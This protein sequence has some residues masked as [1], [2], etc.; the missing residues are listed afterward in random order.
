[1]KKKLFIIIAFFILIV[2]VTYPL[3]F[4]IT[5]CMPG[6]SSTD[7]SVASVWQ[8]W[9]IK[10]SWQNKLSLVH[11]QL[12]S[13]PFGIDMISPVYN[14]Y[15]WLFIFYALSL[16]TTP[17]LTYNLQIILNLFLSC[18]FTYLLAHLITKSRMGAFFSAICFAFCPYQFARVWQHLGLTYNQWIPLV[19]F[20]VFLL[21]KNGS[22]KTTF[23]FALSLLLLFSF[24]WTIMFLGGFALGIYLLYELIYIFKNKFYADRD[25]IREEKHYWKRIVIAGLIVFVMLLPQFMPVIK[26]RLA[27][28]P[29]SEGSAYNFHRRPFEDLFLQSAKPLSYLLPATTHPVFG[30]FTEQFIGS[31]LYGVSLTEHALYLGWIPLILAFMAFRA[32]RSKSKSISKEDNFFI[33]YFI[34]L[35]VSAWLFSQPP[36]WNIGSVKIYMPSFFMYK[37]IPMYRA[38]C[39]FG[40]VVMLAVAVLSGF[41]LKLLLERF[42]KPIAKVTVAIFCCGLLLFEFWSWPPYK[43]ID[44]SKAPNVYTWLK[45]QPG[46]FV[47]AEYPSD[48]NGIN[49]MHKFYQTKHEKKMING[50][51]PGTDA[52][53]LAIIIKNLSDPKTAQ[54]LKWLDVKYAIVHRDDYLMSELIDQAQEL[55]NI[56]NN[57]NIKLIKSFPAQDCPDKDIMCFQKTGPIDVYLINANPL[58]PEGFTK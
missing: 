13:Y 44:I 2:I 29:A 57:P 25:R 35:A 26:N 3:C 14:S 20:S 22:N 56:R 19:L 21:R 42:K 5:T 41:G 58:K 12:I 27:P 28:S 18:M 51:I 37:F 11:T 54:I 32:W 50:G 53:K 34:L 4:K 9:L 15:I 39:R 30:K 55:N 43:V 6:F 10:F 31:Q 16:F 33:G 17:V 8:S 45:N 38:Y 40:I 7:E 46:D 52:N 23:L 36:W 49:D 48:Y 47:I 24:D 1:M